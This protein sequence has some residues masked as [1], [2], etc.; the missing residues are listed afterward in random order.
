MLAVSILDS[1]PTKAPKKPLIGRYGTGS[2]IKAIK[3][4]L[5]GRNGTSSVAK[6]TK[7]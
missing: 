5:I 6:A 2:V 1:A 7:A 4:P 3:K